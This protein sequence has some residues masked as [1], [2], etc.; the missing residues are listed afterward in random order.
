VNFPA[1][2]HRVAWQP[3][4]PRG[5]AAFAQA[6]LARLLIFQFA[7]AA[8]AA[9]TLAWF[10]HVNCYPPVRAAIQQLPARGE[11]RSGRLDW[12]G[13]SPLLLAENHYL[14]FAV[15]LNHEGGTRS[16]AHFEVQF[17]QASVRIYSLFGYAEWLYPTNWIVGFNRPEAEP[18]WGAW[19]PPILGIT[20]LAV[21]AG[22]MLCWSL[23]ALIG[24]WGVWLIGFL[25]NRDLNFVA[26]WKLAGAALM[27][28]ALLMTLGILLY[29]SGVL[30]LVQCLFVAALHLAAGAF[31]GL[32]S[33]F[34]APGLP[35]PSR[36]GPNPFASPDRTHRADPPNR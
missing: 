2:A 27:P 3:L 33:P 32:L 29:G 13:P 25:A 35:P 20:L 11:I 19:S 4:T 22:L 5:V 16:S 15:D 10:V 31:Y 28:G 8:L 9:G 24:C 34:F 7:F 23:L 17:G 21:V 12:T 30:D 14:A 36:P 6:P 1:Q 18:W 26:S